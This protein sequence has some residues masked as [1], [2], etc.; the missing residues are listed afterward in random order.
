MGLTVSE[1]A[2]TKNVWGNKRV[3]VYDVTFDSSYPDN[4][5]ALTAATLGFKKVNQVLPH[6]PFR[7]ADG[8]SA[9]LVSYDHTN[10]KLLA[11][12][13]G[14]TAQD[15]LPENTTADISTYSGRITVIGTGGI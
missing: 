12:T 9:L 13:S 10:S 3:R 2:G 14:S 11:F 4:G 5:E 7:A 6:G 1:V 15:P 8:S